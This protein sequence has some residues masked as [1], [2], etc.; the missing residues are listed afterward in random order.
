MTPSYYRCAL[1][2]KDISDLT[3]FDFDQEEVV[4]DKYMPVKDLPELLEFT[5][6]KFKHHDV[7]EHCNV[8]VI[9]DRSGPEI[10]KICKRHPEISYIRVDNPK[11]FNYSNLM[12]IGAYIS[13]KL[14]FA[15]V[16]TWNSDMWPP[17]AV[18]VPELIRRHNEASCTVSGTKLIYPL[19]AWNGEEVTKNVSYHYPTEKETFRGTVQYGGSI[20]IPFGPTM[21]TEHLKR[22]GSPDNPMVNQD[23]ATI[24]VTGAYSLVQLEWL[25]SSGGLN[26]S[27]SKIFNDSDMCMRAIEENKTVMYFGK[28]IYLNHDES[29]NLSNEIKIDKQFN[30]DCALYPKIWPL[31]RI[32]RLLSK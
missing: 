20:L 31:E 7:M 4:F 9:D 32:L 23:Y 8:F 1:F 22:F 21:T 14:G 26:P 29:V 5:L 18:T 17:D 24:F 16:I 25:V 15:Q 12:N 2:D 10:K 19:E 3:S 6:G 28:D 13:N 30:S 11:G 27:L